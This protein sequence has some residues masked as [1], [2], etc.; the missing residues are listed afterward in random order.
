[1]RKKTVFIIAAILL[2]FININSMAV[3]AK[4]EFTS[5]NP[6]IDVG[7]KIYVQHNADNND[8]YD[9]QKSGTGTTTVYELVLA[10]FTANKAWTTSGEF[11]DNVA[12]KPHGATAPDKYISV[13]ANEQ[14]FIKTYG[15]GY[16]TG[17]TWYAPVLFLDDNDTVI[18]DVLTNT[19][20]ASKAG[21]MITVPENATKMHLTMYNNQSFSLKKC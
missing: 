2:L 13:T 3:C 18:A 12:E 15:V 14:Y 5:V 6:V 11:I 8:I 19:L 1:M 7:E 16:N 20:S 9:L 21:V 10:E 4:E 17:G